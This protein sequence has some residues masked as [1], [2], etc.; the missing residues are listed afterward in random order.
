MSIRV[1]FMKAYPFFNENCTHPPHYRIGKTCL[2]GIA[3]E[4]IGL[5]AS[6]L[7]LTID[8]VRVSDR[9]PGWINAFDELYKNQTDVYGLFFGEH[10]PTFTS[11]YDFTKAI[12]WNKIKVVVRRPD[13]SFKNIFDFFKMYHFDTWI[14]M[15]LVFMLFTAFGLL[16][17]F[18]EYQL[19]L[20]DKCNFAEVFL[21]LRRLNEFVLGK[22]SLLIFFIFQI[23]IILELYESLILTKIIHQP[24][25]M[26][27]TIDEFP[28]MVKERKLTLVVDSEDSNWIYEEI[29]N[30]YQSPFYELREALESNPVRI[31]DDVMQTIDKE[32]EAVTLYVEHWFNLNIA[33]VYCRLSLVDVS[34]QPQAQ[35]FMFKKGSRFVSMFNEAI[36]VNKYEIK[37]ILPEAFLLLNV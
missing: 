28:R 8:V 16:V 18:A 9:V 2:S 19:K 33:E 34:I 7:N 30:N 36:D 14:S 1:S 15:I 37:S 24:E 12:Y 3:V 25:L 17:Q 22:I 21:T 32:Y 23:C 10:T 20:R 29:K 26:P 35:R 4:I 5:I 31:V 13:H 11:R 27:F 6:H